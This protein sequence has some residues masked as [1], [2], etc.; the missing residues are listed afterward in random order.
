MECRNKYFRSKPLDY[1]LVSLGGFLK[2]WSAVFLLVTIALAL[3]KKE[4]PVG[5][6]DPDMDVKKV[7][8]IMWSIIRLKSESS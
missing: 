3:F 4:D 1:G 7:Y 2:F 5:S 6:D 8:S